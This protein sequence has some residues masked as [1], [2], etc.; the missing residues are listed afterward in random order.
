[1]S[2]KFIRPKVIVKLPRFSAASQW[3]AT[4]KGVLGT[5]FFVAIPQSGCHSQS[6]NTALQRKPGLWQVK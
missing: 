2:G 3:T 1:L 6:S 4:L 5:F